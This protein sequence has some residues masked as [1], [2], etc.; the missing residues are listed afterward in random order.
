MAVARTAVL[1]CAALCGAE[2]ATLQPRL[3]PLPVG[4]VTPSGWLLQ[5]LVIQAQGLTGHLS[6]FW[7]DVMDSMWIGGSSDT[8]LHERTPYWLNGIVPLRFLLENAGTTGGVNITAQ[9]EK[10]VQYILSHQADDGWLGPAP[11]PED[12]NTYW[13]PSNVLFALLQYGE[14][15]SK[16]DKTNPTYVKAAEAILK[17]LQAAR[18]LMKTTPLTGWAAARWQDLA[19]TVEWLLD[20]APQGQ[21]D[22][23]FEMLNE[24]ALTG[25]DWEYWF[26]H[27]QDNGRGANG[28]NVNNAQ[29]LKSSGVLYRFNSTYKLDNKTLEELSVGRMANL[30]AFYGLPTG[31]FNGDEYIPNP[32]TRSP[33]RGIELC[34]VVEAMF[35]YTV[36]H[37]VFPEHT[38]FADRTELI[39]YN[40]LPATWA[41]PKGGDM[42]AHQYLQAINEINAI[43]ATEHT[44]QTD[45]PMSETYGLEP[46]FGCC[47]ANFNQGWPKLASNLFFV[48]PSGAVIVAL[49]APASARFPAGHNI[50]V[51]TDYPFSDI[52]TVTLSPT[53][54]VDLQLR[55][56]GWA[57]KATVNGAAVKS[58]AYYV[59][60]QVATTTKFVIDLKAEV[61]V[62]EWDGGAVSVHHGV[63]MYSLPITPAYTT[64][65]KHYLE[66][67]DYYLNPTSDWGFALDVNMSNPAATMQ[68]ESSGYVTGSAPFNHS[69]WPTSITATVRSLQWGIEKNSAS[70]PPVSPACTANA[71]CGPPAQMRLVPHGG[72][73]LRIGEFPRSGL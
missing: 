49:Y 73:E 72:T 64:Y 27:F 54:P 53:A 21:E 41:S 44:W 62:E 13:G 66:S 38:E 71:A 32:A 58:G 50:S 60:S 10:Y 23:L 2:A 57:T 34:G 43:N 8:A 26:E 15:M 55:I 20:N 67:N 69:G 45:G 47:T 46:N 14:G 48:S 25:S 22:F 33:S 37:S 11:N 19:L 29:A 28:H 30:D 7:P 16:G 24:L 70:N 18:K 1:L 68:F 6:E 65:A 42:W 52:I 36:L 9:V 17:H 40:A 5:Q 61:R 59:V 31:M 4:S 12:G 51:V 35:S 56:P 3:T 63:L 39:A